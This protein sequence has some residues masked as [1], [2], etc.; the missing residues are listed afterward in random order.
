MTRALQA[1]SPLGSEEIL[2]SIGGAPNSSVLANGANGLPGANQVAG[3]G[4]APNA[5]LMGGHHQGGGGA[6][7]CNGSASNLYLGAPVLPAA[8]AILY[9]QVRSQFPHC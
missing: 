5:M 7:H 9:S 1:E 2:P 6:A 4:A 3:A 8:S